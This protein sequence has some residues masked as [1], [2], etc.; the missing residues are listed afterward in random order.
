M[1]LTSANA[2]KLIKKLNEK[3]SYLQSMENNGCHYIAADGETPVIPD[4]KYEETSKQLADI[5]AKIVTIKHALNT[6]NVNQ[7]ID[8][9]GKTMTIDSVLIRMAQ[10]NQRKDKLDNLRKTPSKERIN[11]RGFGSNSL[12]EYRYANFDI[13][14]VNADFDKIDSEITA[15]QLALDKFNQTFEFDVDIEL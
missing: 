6:V 13:K 5:D 3:K 8:V 10:L 14:S 2:N 9:N 15:L 4:Y 1:K 7:T 11:S 12:I